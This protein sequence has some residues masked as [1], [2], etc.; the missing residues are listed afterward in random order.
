MFNKEYL[1]T[2]GM[3]QLRIF[4]FKG[5]ISKKDDTETEV[6]SSL[7]ILE[8]PKCPRFWLAREMQIA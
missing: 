3:V 6:L 7:G 2:H 4:S 5:L 8:L 1:S